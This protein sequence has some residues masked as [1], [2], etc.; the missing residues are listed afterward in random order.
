MCMIEA[1]AHLTMTYVL[2]LLRS[3]QTRVEEL[4]V[5]MATANEWLAHSPARPVSTSRALEA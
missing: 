4:T 5:I 2:A 3:V 1:V